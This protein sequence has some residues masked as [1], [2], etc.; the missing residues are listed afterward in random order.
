MGEKLEVDVIEFDNELQHNAFDCGMFV[1]EGLLS[2]FSTSTSISLPTRGQISAA[3]NE[4]VWRFTNDIA[5]EE[6][7]SG[8]LQRVPSSEDASVKSPVT[9]GGHD[10]LADAFAKRRA[11]YCEIGFDDA[12]LALQYIHASSRYEGLLRAV[13]LAEPPADE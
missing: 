9:G 8:V 11:L 5:Q 4:W 6:P 7:S 1:I 13:L 2:A 10:H 12:V 3:R